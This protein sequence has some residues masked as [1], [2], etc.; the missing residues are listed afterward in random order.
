MDFFA[1][2]QPIRKP[3]TPVE[4]DGTGGQKESGGSI[5]ESPQTTKRLVASEKKIPARISNFYSAYQ[6][7]KLETES[8]SHP[9]INKEQY[10]RS[11]TLT[12]DM[13]D[14]S[15]V[16]KLP[17]LVAYIANKYGYLYGF[18]IFSVKSKASA[19][20]IG[21]LCCLQPKKQCRSNI[22]AKYDPML[23]C[24]VIEAD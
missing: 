24:W 5:L 19:L 21:K 7:Q 23:H 22:R 4:Q 12:L 8:G 16:L 2:K 1:A 11:E 3:C 10:S 14:V 15:K 17:A 20:V 13:S 18:Q 9:T 6:L